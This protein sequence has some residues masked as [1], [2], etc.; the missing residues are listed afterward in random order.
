[1]FTIS[2]KSLSLNLIV[3]LTGIGI[4]IFCV[5]SL[6]LA[7]TPKDLEDVALRLI[8]KHNRLDL[9]DLVIVNSAKGDYPHH[10]KTVF[11]FKVIDSLT[12]VPYLMTL[13]EYGQELDTAQ[14]DADQELAYIS[15]FGRFEEELAGMLATA[16]EDE[17]INVIIWLKEPHIPY[18]GPEPPEINVGSV[19]PDKRGFTTQEEIDAFRA[20]VDSHRDA[21]VA[22][23]VAP[24]YERMRRLGYAFNIETS[25]P[26]IYASLLPREIREIAK[27]VE[28]DRIY[29]D[30][31]NQS[32]LEYAR[33]TIGAHIVNN[34]GITGSG[35]K[36]AQIEVGGRIATT[37]PYLSGTIQDTTYVCSSAS[38]HSTAV[39]GIIRSTHTSVRGI[40]PGVTLQAGGSCTGSSSELQSQSTTAAAWGALVFNLSWGS[41]IGRT[42]GVN[43]RFYDDLV[44]TVHVLS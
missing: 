16:P 1:M 14:L 6:S 29:L 18:A 8:T 38:G 22:A 12:Q 20:Q 42:L 4:S 27:W 39:A 28:I 34:R 3:L 7:Q 35:V 26:V 17:A 21:A 13:D 33:P 31:I 37:N 19:T 23:V 43:D 10:G 24:I 2:Y 11:S 15:K 30:R 41:N 44:S 40:A 32:E 9:Q 5:S 36:V 25:S